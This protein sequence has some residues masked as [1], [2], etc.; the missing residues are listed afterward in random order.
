MAFTTALHS[1]SYAGVWTGQARLSL[2]DFLR[3]A[4]T[5]GFDGV[6]LMAK[7]PHL[8][9]LDCDAS[10]CDELRRLIRELD[11]KVVCL[12]GYNDF[13]LG[14]ERPDIPVREMQVLYARELARLAER[15]DCKL[16]RIFT[17]YDDQRSSYD[18]QWTGT[19][20][21]L[22]ECARAAARFGVTVGVQNHHDTAVHFET[23]FDLLE[24]VAEPNCKA[25]FD[26]WAPALH[27]MNLE[28]AVLKMAPYIVHTT[29][30]D[31]VRRP[32]FRYQPALVNYAREADSI[33]AVPMGEGFIDYRTFFRTLHKVGYQGAVAYEMCSYLKGGGSEANL[34]RCARTFLD[35]MRSAASRPAIG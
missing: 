5:L 26:A 12:A 18:Q 22:R 35:Y 11:L 34:D 17:S 25:M 19:V 3:K 32:R 2:V 24:E 9:V 31:Y 20:T 29:V 28:A 6:M 8:S 21:S 16:I 27:G 10:A 1:V 14:S 7:R 23:M 13:T 30:A 33:R 4:R 15:L